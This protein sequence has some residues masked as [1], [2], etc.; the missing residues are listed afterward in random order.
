MLALASSAILE[1][2]ALSS[3]AIS[4]AED[5]HCSFFTELEHGST[6]DCRKVEAWRA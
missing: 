1:V 2:A 3:P 5:E 4:R 6:S